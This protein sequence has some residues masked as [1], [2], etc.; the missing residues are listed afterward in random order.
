M[1]DQ[2]EQ[3]NEQNEQNKTDQSEQKNEQNEQK[4]TDQSEAVSDEFNVIANHFRNS[5]F[6]MFEKAQGITLFRE[7][8]SQLQVESFV[9]GVFSGVVTVCFA[10]IDDERRGNMMS[11]LVDCLMASRAVVEGCERAEMEEADE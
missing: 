8:S 7:L 4:K 11:S 2:S 10:A 6:D 5:A 3:K 1:T 9:A